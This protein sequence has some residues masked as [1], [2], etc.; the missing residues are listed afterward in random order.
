MREISVI[1]SSA[2]VCFKMADVK[3]QHF[4]EHADKSNNT[5]KKTGK[6]K[7][8]INKMYRNGGI[9]CLKSV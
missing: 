2:G 9:C 1:S 4:R 6:K 7:Y 3:L 5:K 8:M